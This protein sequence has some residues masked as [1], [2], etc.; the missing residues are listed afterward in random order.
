[1]QQVHSGPQ[2]GLRDISNQSASSHHHPAPSLGTA[3]KGL[4]PAFIGAQTPGT[5]SI[6]NRARAREG[7]TRSASA[8]PK[9]RTVA[10]PSPPPP[11]QAHNHRRRAHRTASAPPP[12]LTTNRGDL[13]VASELI[14][15]DKT[16]A[17]AAPP[18]A[19]AVSRHLVWMSFADGGC[20]VRN[21]R[22]AEVV[23]RF[24]SSNS[25]GSRNN[26]AG[27][28]PLGFGGGG[29]G[30]YTGAPLGRNRDAAGSPANKN[31]AV[32]IHAILSVVTRAGEPHV[33][34]ALSTGAIEVHHGETA[35]LIATLR[36]HV[37]GAVNA[38]AE[39]GGLVYS[40]GK[41]QH[42]VQWRLEGQRYVRAFLGSG[43]AGG[44][45]EGEI[46]SLYA[47]G[48]A[49]VS[50]SADD[51]V[52]VWDVGSGQMQ[53]TGYFHAQ[54]HGVTALCRGNSGS[55]DGVGSDGGVMWSGDGTGHIA[56]WSLRSCE[57][58]D[59]L[60]PHAAKVTALQRCGS[61]VYSSSAD[62]TIAVLCAATG[63][64][65]KRIEDQATGWVTCLASPAQL[66]RF[67]VWSADSHG[68][69]QCWY[70]DEHSFATRDGEL[71]SDTAWYRSG[72]TPYGEFRRS[73]GESNA[74][75]AEQLLAAE[76]RDP[77][78]TAIL[79]MCCPNYG[80]KLIHHKKRNKSKGSD[81]DGDGDTAATVSNANRNDAERQYARLQDQ[82]RMVED[83]RSRVAQDLR[84]TSE[85]NGHV[86]RDLATIMALLNAAVADLNMLSP[87]YGDRLVATMPAVPVVQ[88]G[89]GGVGG[90]YS[91]GGIPIYNS[92]IT[93]GAGAVG[94]IP[95]ILPTAGGGAGAVSSLPTNP[96]LP[97]PPLSTAAT[98]A[99]PI[100]SAS[101]GIPGV[102]VGG[103]VAPLQ[104]LYTGVPLG[105]A[106]ATGVPGVSPVMLP[107][108][109]GSII[110][111][112]Q[113]ST[114]AMSAQQPL[115]VG[116]QLGS[117]GTGPG[118]VGTGTG[119]P[120]LS[121]QQQVVALL[122]SFNRS[123]NNTAGGI[124]PATGAAAD[125]VDWVNPNVGNYIQRRY[126]G[127]APG[128]RAP[129]LSRRERQRGRMPIVKVV[130]LQRSAS[131]KNTGVSGGG[132]AGDGK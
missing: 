17:V 32:T 16:F 123:N 131:R 24:S 62:G 21:T 66:T 55:A 47:E 129:D 90:S 73:I 115:G 5:N 6:S 22:T 126:Y 127:A 41:D 128:L 46:I 11:R 121:H 109:G 114:T 69:V 118:G 28:A 26:T 10:H 23:K 34:L 132:G 40:A 18:L 56:R 39:F 36:L 42:V 59:I 35:A 15:N 83:R 107:P 57:V 122:A 130:P 1:M 88:P 48:N 4:L 50:G 97:P 113:T 106:S 86:E 64:I 13:H 96:M 44:G 72:S 91:P 82:M 111:P 120:Q 2:R 99:A 54:Q 78:V 98:T 84:R 124:D 68:R 102:G 87:G 116:G 51:T 71:L 125:A 112:G 74:R 45:H 27:G 14:V 37:G 77:R 81:G 85:D 119:G 49:L 80:S 105:A 95:G 117:A 70:Q 75:L 31:S 92:S 30:G 79:R 60:R 52:K 38:L 110:L 58:L 103:V 104:P 9:T 12:P 43:S 33:W 61:R 101:M 8:N 53:L 94:G 93:G 67:V 3:H 76:C 20:E 19:M 63:T 65:L 108:P 29:G 100:G 25:N 89:S 7:P